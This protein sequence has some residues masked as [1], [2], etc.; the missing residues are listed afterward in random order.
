MG[1]ALFFW[2]GRRHA[3]PQNA[4]IYLVSAET[5]TP[6]QAVSPILI[7]DD[8]EP[9]RR[10][11]G[12]WVER[13]GYAVRTA[14]SAE[15]AVLELDRGP[16]SVVLCD[17]RMPGHDG[18]WLA[19]QIRVKF[20]A[21]AV[22]L[23]T[24]LDELD[25]ALTLRPGIVGYVTKPFERDSIAGAIGTALEWSRTRETQAGLNEISLLEAIERWDAG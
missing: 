12:Q 20:P 2:R 9:I 25:A 5:G 7:V 1:A 11:L 4:R 24:G 10:I 8:E 14:A 17:V 16:I 18:V 3:G 6:P 23:V 15:D 13:L 21:V 19:D 22:V